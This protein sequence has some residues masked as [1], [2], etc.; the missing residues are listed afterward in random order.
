LIINRAGTLMLLR[1]LVP[2][3]V[4]SAA[5]G[6]DVTAALR[7]IGGNDHFFLNLVDPARSAGLVMD[8]RVP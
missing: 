2:Q 3:L 5:P 1:D 6:G 8:R 4:A 7:F